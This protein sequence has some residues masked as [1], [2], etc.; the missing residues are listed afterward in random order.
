[1][2]PGV[3]NNSKQCSRMKATTIHCID[4][5][6]MNVANV[7]PAL[8]Y[9]IYI[10]PNDMIHFLPSKWRKE[11]NQWYV[12]FLFFLNT[13]TQFC[14]QFSCFLEECNHKSETI[15]LRKDHS[16]RMHHLP[17]DFRCFEMIP[18]AK[19]PHNNVESNIEIDEKKEGTNNVFVHFGHHQTKTFDTSYAKALSGS[20]ARAAG[21]KSATAAA[22]GLSTVLD[23]NNDMVV[24]LMESLPK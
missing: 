4:I 1:M 12:S 6:V 14:C 5:C 17:A 15:E 2:F 11:P 20:T 7:Y 23:D 21:C 8:I 24:D 3:V 18:K 9:L 13:S 19:H 10:C 22:R 16:I